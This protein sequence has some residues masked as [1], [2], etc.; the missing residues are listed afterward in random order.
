[1][2]PLGNLF[3]WL[4]LTIKAWKFPETMDCEMCAGHGTV[5]YRRSGETC[6]A[7]RGDGVQK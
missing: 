6:P 3:H 4:R 5:S 2:K 1:M 7:C